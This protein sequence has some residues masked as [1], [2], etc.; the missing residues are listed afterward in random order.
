MLKIKI[1]DSNPIVKSEES[2]SFTI[3]YV[4][5]FPSSS[6]AITVPTSVWFSSTVN[7]LLD[8]NIGASLI[9][10]I[11]TTMFWVI[12]VIPSLAWTVNAYDCL[13]S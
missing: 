10:L 3:E 4:T 2:S 6:L 7:M 11:L 13:V 9:L 5:A 1:P 8:V 12:D